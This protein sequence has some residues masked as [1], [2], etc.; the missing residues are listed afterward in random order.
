[1]PAACTCC[2]VT[3]LLEQRTAK[4]MAGTAAV[5]YGG[6]APTEFAGG[7]YWGAFEGQVSGRV[8]QLL[9]QVRAV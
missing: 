6:T 3:E 7:D 9:P 4:F 5:L 2:C 8:L 1:M